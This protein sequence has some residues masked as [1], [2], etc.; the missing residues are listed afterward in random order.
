MK[1]VGS[2]SYSPAVLGLYISLQPLPGQM[3]QGGVHGDNNQ[4]ELSVDS[5]RGFEE[6][7]VDFICSTA[8]SR[9]VKDIMSILQ[10][11]H[12][13]TLPHAPL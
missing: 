13:P 8:I 3:S 5:R 1:M 10:S 9:Y 4:M 6:Y 2:V 7:V 12:S 11:L